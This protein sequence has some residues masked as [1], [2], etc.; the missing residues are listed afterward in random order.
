MTQI[1]MNHIAKYWVI[2]PA[3]GLGKRL[4]AEKPKQYLSIHSKAI[5]W[6]TLFCLINHP[7]IHKIIVA[8]AQE[9]PYWPEIETSLASS[10]IIATQGG[11]TRC[12]S[13]Y[14]ALLT[15]Q[16]SA[17]PDDWI[18]VHDAVRPCLQRAQLDHLI[19]TLKDHPVGG[20]L[21]VRVTDTLK[22]TDST[23]QVLNTLDRTHLWQA[24]TPQLF[25]YQLLMDSLK[26]A[27][28]QHQKMTDEASAISFFGHQP[29]MVEGVS[30]NIKIT[31]PED[32]VLAASILR[33]A[34]IST[35]LE[36]V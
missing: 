6:H 30:T 33:C 18:L 14:Q 16:K 19:H 34:T 20:L 24:Q 32:L 22:K 9:D 31:Y 5:I 36:K 15:L 12:A 1:N 35:A 10:K 26:N 29:M 13:V 7:S 11:A 17:D 4:G 8:I 23:H 28:M 2:V 21:G 27:R 3:A 25:R